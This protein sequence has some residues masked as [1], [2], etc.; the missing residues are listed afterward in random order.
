MIRRVLSTSLIAA[1][2]SVPAGCSSGKTG[3]AASVTPTA[4][5]T[6][7]S[8]AAV[9]ATGRQ[10]ALPKAVIYKTSADVRLNVP[11]TLD[12]AGTGLLSYPAPSDIFPEAAPLP[13][14]D[15]FLLDRRGV[16][17]NSAFTTYTY[18]EYSALK[19]APTPAELMKAII[20]GVRVTE[21]VRLPFTT[22]VA[23][24]DTAEVNRLIRTGLPGCDILL[25]M[26]PAP[27]APAK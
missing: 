9:M 5:A 23:V 24:A 14:A 4:E 19:T 16:G 27:P 1:A 25:D 18:A 6:A 22:S 7:V 13:L 20:P 2:L 11:V 3:A 8:S 12:D 21:I 17:P 26:P 10:N 15:G